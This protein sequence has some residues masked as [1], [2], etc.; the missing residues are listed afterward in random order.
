MQGSEIDI[1]NVVASTKLA[2]SFKLEE[3]GAALSGA[4][5]NKAKF[6]GMVYKVMDPK[7][8]FLIFASGKVVCTGVKKIDDV[9][10]VIL[11][12]AKK[13]ATLG[14]D[15]IEEPVITIQNIVASA[16]LGTSLN[17]NALAVGIGFENIEYEPEQFPGLVYRI[18]SPKIVVLIFSSGKLVITG[19]KTPEDCEKGVA[20]VRQQL[21]N[22]YL[23]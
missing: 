18:N 10:T 17:L 5:Y 19:G 22:M 13:I 11:N 16:D 21:E 9:R 7:A 3:I 8:A 12:V 14:I 4:E 23:I 1:Q 15:I 2:D 6:P 20:I